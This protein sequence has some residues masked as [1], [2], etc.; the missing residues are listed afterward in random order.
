MSFTDVNG[1][2]AQPAAEPASSSLQT[3]ILSAAVL[4]P[5][6]LA[7]LYFGGLGF[8]LLLAAAAVLMAL[9]WDRL[10]GGKRFAV[11]GIAS[12][13]ALVAVLT[14]Q[15]FGYGDWAVAAL[16]PLAALLAVVN[17][18]NGRG[19]VWAVI[20][21]FWLGLP[22][23]SL[24][25]LRGGDHGALVVLWLF[26]AVWACDTGAYFAGRG[27]GG[28]KLAPRVS[29]KK[30]WAGL[31]GGMAAAAAVSAAMAVIFDQ[32][33]V[34]LFIAMGALLALVS[35]IG[36]LAE[37]GVKRHFGVKD[38]GDLIPG[39]GGILDRVDGVLFAAPALAL[40]ALQQ[41]LAFMP[42]L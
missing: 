32:R 17:R 15:F 2:M 12:A 23:L 29:P 16:L 20:G 25:W 39:H 10:T 41:G 14:L 30:T 8:W 18:I 9:E 19:V 5:V 36:D 21:L 11:T 6:V 40:I 38:S 33:S 42:W 3:R 34:L 24:F 35:Q 13:L 31:L 1:V 22:C 26:F 27:I 7:L 37:S 28:P 4:M